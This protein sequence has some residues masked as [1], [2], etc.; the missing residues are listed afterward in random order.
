RLDVSGSPSV[1]DLLHRVRGQVLAAQRHQDLPFEQVVEISRPARSLSHSPLFQV[2]FAWQNTGEET[3]ELSGLR[4]APVAA[5]HVTSKFDLTLSLGEAGEIIAGGVEYA[6][7]LFERAT[8]ERH[9]EYLRT[10]LEA[11]VADE[12]QAVD[13]L[14]LLGEAKRRQVL[15]EWNDSQAP[16]PREKCVHELFE[17]Q[18]ERTPEAIAVVQE[19]RQLS[20]GELNARAN[21]LAA[22]LRGLGVGPDTCVAICMEKNLEMV[23]G[24]LAVLKAGAAYV[25]MDPSH[26]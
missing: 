19:I 11:M 26:P 3:L 4:L 23:V 25:P 13:R 6:T 9:L 18:V 22:H 2:M 21:R 10:L 8:I 20:Y 14:P 7:A 15:I 5:P 24:L 12:A 1:I 16:Y 17:A